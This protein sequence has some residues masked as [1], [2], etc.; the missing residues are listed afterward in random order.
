MSLPPPQFSCSL[1]PFPLTKFLERV[2]VSSCFHFPLYLRLLHVNSAHLLPI[3]PRSLEHFSP[4]SPKPPLTWSLH[5]NLTLLTT[6][7]LLKHLALDFPDISLSSLPSFVFL[8]TSYVG[9]LCK[10]FM[11]VFLG[12]FLGVG[13]T[14]PLYTFPGTFQ[15]KL[16]LKWSFT[17]QR[18]QHVFITCVCPAL[19]THFGAWYRHLEAPAPLRHKQHFKPSPH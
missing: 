6:L 17:Y 15:P 19:H 12:C 13:P 4:R 2:A 1:S 8:W 18:I 16:L 10:L 7:F 14:S 5:Q 11:P 9:L 3:V